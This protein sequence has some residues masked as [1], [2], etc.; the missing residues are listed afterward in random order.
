MTFNHYSVDALAY[1]IEHLLTQLKEAVISSKSG[2]DA[3]RFSIFARSMNRIRGCSDALY[4]LVDE[5]YYTN[6]ERG[7]DYRYMRLRN[8]L[9]NWL[10]LI[11]V[12]R[13]DIPQTLAI[14]DEMLEDFNIALT[15]AY[16]F[17][18]NGITQEQHDS[19]YVPFD[20]INRLK[21]LGYH[22]RHAGLEYIPLHPNGSSLIRRTCREEMEAWYYC[23]TNY[24]RSKQIYVD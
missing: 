7:P 3:E 5:I 1:F 15:V 24:Q 11:E 14:I 19:W 12:S 18:G 22:V 21:A 23:W 2:F 8:A 6:A 17:Y 16:I 10:R 9:H 13:E 20:N 4:T